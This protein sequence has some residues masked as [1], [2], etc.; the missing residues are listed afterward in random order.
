[1]LPGCQT[2]APSWQCLPRRL[3]FL[4]LPP[5]ELNEPDY[6]DRERHATEED[7]CSEQ[8]HEV[9]VFLAGA[10]CKAASNSR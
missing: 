7:Q 2:A 6:C 8:D 1:M 9:D 5:Q 10:C 4:A 3:M